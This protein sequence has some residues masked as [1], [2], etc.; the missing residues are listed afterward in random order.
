MSTETHRDVLYSVPQK[1]MEQLIGHVS[2][3]VRIAQLEEHLTCK[4]KGCRFNPCFLNHFS[5]GLIDVV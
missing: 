5:K 2:V 4:S 1:G 3:S